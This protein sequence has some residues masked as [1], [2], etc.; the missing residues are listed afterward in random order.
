M[1][2]YFGDEFSLSDFKMAIL[3]GYAGPLFPT[4]SNKTK[5]IPGRPGAWDF[6]IDVGPRARSYPIVCLAQDSFERERLL[7]SFAGRLFDQKA[8]PKTF[9]IR[10]SYEPEL[11]VECRVSA[12]PSAKYYRGG[13]ADFDLQLTAYNDPFKYG[14]QTAFDPKEPVHYG[15]VKPGDYYKNPVSFDWKY[16]PHYYGCFNYSSLETDVILTIN[17]GSA[18]NASVTHLE[19]RRTLTLPDFSNKKIVIDTFKKTI[20]INDQ[21]I[22]SG[23]NLDFFSL[24]PGKNSF[25]FRGEGVRGKVTS[26]WYHKFM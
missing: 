13:H 16:S 18:K 19:S 11:W 25:E 4:I 5:N 21:P 17:N 9:K 8:G 24:H 22:V 2:I 1:E 12:T 20:F 7:R 15:K 6:G 3:K 23:S 26:M 10:T 14:E